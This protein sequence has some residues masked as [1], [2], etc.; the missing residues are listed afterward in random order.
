MFEAYS[1][2]SGN[3]EQLESHELQKLMKDYELYSDKVSQV[4]VQLMFA[5]GNKMK[6]C[7]RISRDH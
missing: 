3:P 1:A 2:C 5:K 6:N 7:S 4:A